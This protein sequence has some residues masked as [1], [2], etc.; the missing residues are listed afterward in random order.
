MI[1]VLSKG[2]INYAVQFPGEGLSGDFLPPAE[3]AL[4]Q[5]SPPLYVVMVIRAYPITPE[6]RKVM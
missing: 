5:Y 2:I 1:V 4:D 6:A 3:G